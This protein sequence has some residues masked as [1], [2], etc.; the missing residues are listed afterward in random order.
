M[1]HEK[2]LLANS[3]NLRKLR[4]VIE[5]KEESHERSMSDPHV[6]NLTVVKVNLAHLA[7]L[8]DLRTSPEYLKAWPTG[9]GKSM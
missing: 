6:S 3:D 1:A 7:R 4:I 5:R 8:L 9:G 2:S